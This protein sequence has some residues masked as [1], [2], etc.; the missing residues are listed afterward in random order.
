M[1]NINVSIV[2]AGNCASALYQGLHYYSSK[3]KNG[4]ISESIGWYTINNINIVAVFDIDKRKVGKTFKEAIFSKPN[5]TPIYCK[6]IKDGP[7]VQGIKNCIAII[8]G[9]MQSKYLGMIKDEAQWSHIRWCSLCF[10]TNR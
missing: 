3:I 1:N 8:E 2:G 7:I 10:I 9:P 5:C 4:L 6:D